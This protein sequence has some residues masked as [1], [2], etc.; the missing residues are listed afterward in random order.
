MCFNLHF[1]S[2]NT[3]WYKEAEPIIMNGKFYKKCQLHVENDFGLRCFTVY[4]CRNYNLTALRI[5]VAFAD[6][7]GRTYTA[8]IK[9]TD[10]SYNFLAT[11]LNF[12]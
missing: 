9:P 8:L 4:G 10:E 1:S 2:E 7:E 12:D 5:T 11:I 6:V 3:T